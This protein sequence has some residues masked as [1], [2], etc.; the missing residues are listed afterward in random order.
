MTTAEQIAESNYRSEERLGILGAMPGKETPAQKR[1]AYQDGNEGV[2][3][4]EAQEKKESELP[5]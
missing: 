4:I 2:N 5:L 3:R 1:L